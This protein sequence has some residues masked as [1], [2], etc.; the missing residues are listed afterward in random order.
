MAWRFDDADV[1]HLSD[2]E[3]DLDLDTDDAPFDYEVPFGQPLL[4]EVYEFEARYPRVAP[5]I[6]TLLRLPTARGGQQVGGAIASQAQALQHGGAARAE[7]AAQAARF[8]I[9]EAEGAGEAAVDDAWCRG[10]DIAQTMQRHWP[11]IAHAMGDCW[12]RTL[13]DAVWEGSAAASPLERHASVVR[14]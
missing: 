7:Q 3:L 9:S 14:D 4:H 2:S 1:V 8:I 11:G 6:R 5:I 13:A 12:L 10:Q